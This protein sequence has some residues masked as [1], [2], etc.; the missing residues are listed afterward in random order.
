MQDKQKFEVVFC[1]PFKIGHYFL[2]PQLLI[3]HPHS[4]EYKWYVGN[5]VKTS[6]SW[7]V[8]NKTSFTYVN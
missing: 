3:L 4:N 2:V 7:P 6:N 5:I 8:K 1:S